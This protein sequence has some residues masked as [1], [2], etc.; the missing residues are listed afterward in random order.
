MLIYGSASG[1]TNFLW[2]PLSDLKSTDK[3][4]PD[5]LDLFV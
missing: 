4:P 1:L 3:F 2:L 5:T